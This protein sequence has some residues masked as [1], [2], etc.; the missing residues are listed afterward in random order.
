MKFTPVSRS[1]RTKICQ[2]R[3]NICTYISEITVQ[4]V[5]LTPGPL[6][7]ALEFTE[8]IFLLIYSYFCSE[9]SVGPLFLSQKWMSF[10]TNCQSRSGK[11]PGWNL[12]QCTWI[13]WLVLITF[14]RTHKRFWNVFPQ[15]VLYTFFP[16]QNWKRS[17]I[18]LWQTNMGSDRNVSM[19][20]FAKRFVQVFWRGTGRIVMAFWR[21]PTWNV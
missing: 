19:A 8:S 20:T 2:M 18:N 7:K 11:S 6:N 9:K 1:C 16:E 13:S 10:C 15:K 21:W 4:A 5:E 3:C 17:S 12:L 14:L